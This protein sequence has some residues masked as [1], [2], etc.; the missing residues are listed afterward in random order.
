MENLILVPQKVSFVGSTF[1]GVLYIFGES[2]NGSSTVYV[3]HIM[4]PR[5]S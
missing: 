3:Y 2:F 1:Y 4:H 5:V